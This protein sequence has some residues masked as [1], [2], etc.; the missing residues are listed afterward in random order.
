MAQKNLPDAPKR[1]VGHVPYYAK[2]GRR[3]SDMSLDDLEWPFGRPEESEG[4]M[5]GDLGP[6]AHLFSF[7]RR[8]LYT[9][10]LK[11]LRA[12]ISLLIVEPASFHRHHMW[13]AKKFHRQFH[14]VLTCNA[15][16]LASIPNGAFFVFG[17][18]WVPD[19]RD[20]DVTKTKML[21]LI[22]SKKRNLVGHKLRHKIVSQMRSAGISADVMGGGYRAFDDKADG[23]AS[24][25]YSVVIENSREPGYFT[26]KLIDALLLNTVPIYWGAPDITKYF[27]LAGLMICT[28]EAEIVAAISNISEA[29]YLA[30]AD[31]I[32][33]NR[34]RA[35][36]YGDMLKS[37]A[38]AIEAT[39]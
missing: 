15:D 17:S 28:N 24:Y 29:D 18:T 39:L 34:R 14:R 11:G 4:K 8:W 36:K 22:A 30:R 12:K 37:A 1:V 13:L 7:P 10:A 26:E 20:K 21:S 23:L 2:V 9:G 19:W 5:V 38:R 16:V 32:G 35:V 31:A 6:D 3:L 25:R 27:D 33:S